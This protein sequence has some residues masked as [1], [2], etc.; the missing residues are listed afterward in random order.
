VQCEAGLAVRAPTSGP[1]G[2]LLKEAVSRGA[3]VIVIASKR[4]TGI[5]GVLGSVAQQVLKDSSIPV[6]VVRA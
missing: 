1:A 2:R 4:A 5:R 6:M 3:D